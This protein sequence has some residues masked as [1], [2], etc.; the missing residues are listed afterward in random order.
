MT[1]KLKLRFEI[2]EK[3]HLEYFNVLCELLELQY[4]TIPPF[5]LKRIQKSHFDAMRA[6]TEMSIVALAGDRAVGFVKLYMSTGG[7]MKILSGSGI[8]IVPE[9]RGKKLTKKFFE[10]T[11]V[12]A[13]QHGFEWFTGES[14]HP[15]VT[16]SIEAIKERKKQFAKGGLKENVTIDYGFYPK[17]SIQINRR[18]KRK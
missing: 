12:F 15:A 8:Y 2:L 10:K 13:R 16:R 11:I 14:S 3:G 7:R 1:G 17:F 9:F 5:E 4:S 18:R 6:G